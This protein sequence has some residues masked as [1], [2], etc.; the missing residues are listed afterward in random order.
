MLLNSYETIKQFSEP[1]LEIH[2]NPIHKQVDADKRIIAKKGR[3]YVVFRFEDIAYF[4]T[5]HGLSYLVDRQNRGKY[6]TAKPL[7]NIETNINSKYFFRVNKKY[8]IHINAVVK[9]KP[10]RRGKLQLVINPDPNETIII[11]QLK[12]QSFKEWILQTW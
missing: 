4:F 7:R 5:E 9:F 8:L 3:E 1:E 2:G 11:S 10:A 6:I 12:A